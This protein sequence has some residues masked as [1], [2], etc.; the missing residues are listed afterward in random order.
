M[1]GDELVHGEHRQPGA[2]ERGD[3]TTDELPSEREE[4]GDGYADRQVRQ[5]ADTERRVA[6][7]VVEQAESAAQMPN[8]A[9]DAPITTPATRSQRMTVGGRSRRGSALMLRCQTCSSERAR[10]GHTSVVW[11]SFSAKL[12]SSRYLVVNSTAGPRMSEASMSDTKCMPR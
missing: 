9:T 4:D 3:G 6:R 5:D 10:R 11:P 2:E 8:A 7:S 1:P 12:R